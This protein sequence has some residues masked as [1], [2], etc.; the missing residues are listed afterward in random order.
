M[1]IDHDDVNH[2]TDDMTYSEVID[3]KGEI[4]ES[5]ADIGRQLENARRRY[6]KTGNYADPEWYRKAHAAKTIKGRQCQRLQG[7]LSKKKREH[8]DTLMQVFMDVAREQLPDERFSE[9]LRRAK[10]LSG[11]TDEQ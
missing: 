2:E 5:I 3:L 1:R 7:V 10:K 4:E 11:Q 8:M 9:L 6:Q